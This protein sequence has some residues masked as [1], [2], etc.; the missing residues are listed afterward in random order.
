MVV[1]LLIGVVFVAALVVFINLNKRKAQRLQSGADVM[2]AFAASI[3]MRF[4]RFEPNLPARAPGVT[5]V[6]GDA[7]LFVDFQLDGTLHGVPFQ[8][9]QVRR[10]PPPRSS[11]TSTPEFTVALV[12]RPVPGPRL[13]VAPQ[14]LSWVTAFRRDIQVGDPAIDAAFHISTD[15]PA[16]AQYLLRSPLGAWLAQDPRAAQVVVGFEPR[17][18]MAVARGPLTPDSAM[19]LA[20]LATNIHRQIPW[21]ALHP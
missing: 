5:D 3:G 7:R 11:S 13:Q 17:D 20:D 14:R 4:G 18:V 1:L 2:A 9:F 21:Q 15:T 12:P 6:V 16:F 10:P 8:V 19:A